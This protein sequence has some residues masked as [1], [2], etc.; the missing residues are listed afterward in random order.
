MPEPAYGLA[1]VITPDDFIALHDAKNTSGAFAHIRTIICRMP[2]PRTYLVEMT[3]AE[4]TTRG[5]LWLIGRDILSSELIAEHTSVVDPDALRSLMVYH[6]QMAKAVVSWNPL[7][8]G[9]MY[10]EDVLQEV[11]IPYEGPL[12]TGRR[13]EIIRE[14]A[15]KRG[16]IASHWRP[17]IS[18]GIHTPR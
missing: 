10:T 9:L 1:E 7:L 12:T 11:H 4:D 15:T 13:F 2:P 5:L 6:E 16:I 17:R 14:I 3:L 18:R 8:S